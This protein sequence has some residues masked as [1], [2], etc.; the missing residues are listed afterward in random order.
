MDRLKI[1]YLI[2]CIIIFQIINT[3][4][5]SVVFR[6]IFTINEMV[7]VLLSGLSTIFPFLLFVFYFLNNFNKFTLR[8]FYFGEILKILFS[9]VI[10]ILIFY[11][12]KINFLVFFLYILLILWVIGLFLY[13][14]SVYI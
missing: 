5:F 11:L 14:N 13:F 2:W 8:K 7:T 10:F 1:Y 12:I 4:I 9:V 6:Y 3:I